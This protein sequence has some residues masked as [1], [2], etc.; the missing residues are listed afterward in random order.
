MAGRRP[1]E[2]ALPVSHS[3]LVRDLRA[4]GL[5]AGATTMVHTSMR[6]LGWVVGGP[7]T[8][9]AALLDVVGA[10][11]TL[12]AYAGWDQDPYHLERWPTRVR[13]VARREQPPFDPLLSE[14]NRDHGRIPERMRTW[15][16]AVRGTHP[17]ASMVAIGRRASWLVSP[18]PD[19]E[20]HGPGT[21]FSRLIE[22]SG[23]VLL[24]GAP[25]ESVTLLHHAEAIAPIEG[26]RRVVYE[27]PVVV[28]GVTTWRTY[29]DIDTSEGAFDYDRLGLDVDPFERI[30]AD[31]LEAGIGRTGHVGASTSVLLP[32]GELVDFAVAW[33]VARFAEAAPE[34]R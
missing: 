32:S 5:E 26:K 14:A 6:R 2:S 12:M 10:T 7:D 31:A 24:L 19:D 3:A 21:P 30:V 4:L 1:H 16:G 11:G 25:W 9:V 17:E 28:D 22:A 13:E 34:H 33:L 8:V 29:H 15:P 27:M 18:H 20:P 23:T